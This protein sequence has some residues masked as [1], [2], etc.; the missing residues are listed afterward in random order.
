MKK[1]LPIIPVLIL[2]F[3]VG[4]LFFIRDS[5]NPVLPLAGSFAATPVSQTNG[6]SSQS[7]GMGDTAGITNQTPNAGI[8]SQTPNTTITIPP[9]GTVIP[10]PE[11]VDSKAPANRMITGLVKDATDQPIAGVSVMIVRMDSPGKTLTSEQVTKTDGKFYFFLNPQQTYTVLAEKEGY[12]STQVEGGYEDDHP[13]LIIKQLEKLIGRVEDESGKPVQFAKVSIRSASGSETGI[14]MLDAQA[15]QDGTFETKEELK[16]GKYAIAASQDEYHDLGKGHK[17]LSLTSPPEEIVLSL[18]SQVFEVRGRVEEYGTG[19]GV[20]GMKVRLLA[21]SYGVSYLGKIGESVSGGD[22]SFVFQNI[23]PG[24]YLACGD[25]P[26]DATSPYLFSDNN[27]KAVVSLRHTSSD[28]VVLYAAKAIE[29][30]GKVVDEKQVPVTD[31]YVVRI[32]PRDNITQTDGE[33]R[34]SFTLPQVELGNVSRYKFL[35]KKTIGSQERYGFSDWLESSNGQPIRDLTLIIETEKNAETQTLKGHVLD[36]AGL[37]V[38]GATIG[39]IDQNTQDGQDTV[40]NE[41]GYYEF[42]NIA[43]I[44]AIQSP[45]QISYTLRIRLKGYA[46]SLHILNPLRG[47]PEIVHDVILDS[48]RKISGCVTDSSGRPLN[49]VSVYASQS[50]CPGEWQTTN[51][52]GNYEFSGLTPGQYDLLFQFTQRIMLTGYL[53]GVQAGNENANIQLRFKAITLNVTMSIP[54]GVNRAEKLNAYLFKKNEDGSLFARNG[55]FLSLA[56]PVFS[57]MLWEP[58]TYQVCCYVP[59]CSMASA[60]VVAEEGMQEDSID[61]TLPLTAIQTMN[62]VTGVV[63]PVDGFTRRF[64]QGPLGNQAP[65]GSDGQFTLPDVPEGFLFLVVWLDHNETGM[66]IKA[67]V[68]IDRHVEGGGVTPIGEIP[69]RRYFDELAFR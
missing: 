37:P 35:A 64:V 65:I 42:P 16:P 61:I 8:S 48:A 12:L 27:R 23:P 10:N 32:E 28:S 38:A 40:S 31:A 63:P 14:V 62:V 51:S 43:T 30:S 3:I 52:K 47:Q 49:G 53:W 54:E 9:N 41:S 6:E 21:W 20:P 2:L 1:I 59:N 7:L 68:P 39:L 5:E 13:I 22:G 29:V 18:A 34:F 15:G 50:G 26:S 44:T 56:S 55:M 11:S 19:K 69:L 66:P 67:D 4:I 60:W 58:G 24:E 33:G 45:F 36:R 25:N 17:E 46:D 57:I